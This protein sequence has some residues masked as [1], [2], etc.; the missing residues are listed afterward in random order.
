MIGP[1]SPR[2]SVSRLHDGSA[3]IMR[4]FL[5]ALGMHETIDGCSCDDDSGVDPG[6][7]VVSSSPCPV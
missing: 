4:G 2:P 5:L 3:E 1:A 6:I 7:S